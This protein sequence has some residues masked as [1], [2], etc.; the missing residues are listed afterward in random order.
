MAYAKRTEPLSRQAHKEHIGYKFR[1]ARAKALA[2][3]RIS[4][5]ED[6]SRCHGPGCSRQA[7]TTSFLVAN[8]LRFCCSTCANNY[9][10]LNPKEPNAQQA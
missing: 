1:V 6:F 3:T 2:K 9:L 10:A 4:F 5:P 8:G 7:K